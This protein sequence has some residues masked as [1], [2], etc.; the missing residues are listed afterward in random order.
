MMTKKQSESQFN[1]GVGVGLGAVVG[2]LVSAIVGMLRLSRPKDEHVS[3][4]PVAQT[5]PPTEHNAAIA[6]PAAAQTIVTPQTHHNVQPSKKTSVDTARAAEGAQNVR[7]G[8]THWRTGTKYFVTALLFLAFIGILYI[9]SQSLSTIIL[10][11]LLTFIVH[12]VVK[13]FQRRFSMRRGSATLMVYLLVLGLILLIPIL[14]VPSLI[15]S[16]QFLANIDYL[17][18][19]ENASKW[20]EQQAAIMSTI[21]L[22][23]T[24]ISSGL[25]QLASILSDIA[26]QNPQGSNSF[27]ISFDNIGGRISQTL[28][29]LGNVFGPLISIATKI[30]FTLLISL[31]MSLSLDLIREGSKKLIP[32]AYQPEISSLVR[33]II[34]IWNS[35]LRGQLSLMV[36]VGVI[37]WIGNVLLGTPQALFLG[38]IAG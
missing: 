11:A 24:S 12:P 16:I 8:S 19:F 18:L 33:K 17:Q 37:V 5:T 38:V 3:T 14:L 10:A 13:F 28:A 9:S 31:H 34:L 36:V 1:W 30:V 4:D 20:I 29:F 35:F 25:D 21:P 23:G 32:T 22:V 26:A 6:A 15:N 27:E 7:A 2:I